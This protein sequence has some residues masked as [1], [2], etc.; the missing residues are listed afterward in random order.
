MI[1]TVPANDSEALSILHERSECCMK[2][3][4]ESFLLLMV[5]FLTW[6][7]NQ[8]VYSKSLRERDIE[9]I[10]KWGLMLL[11]RITCKS[12]VSTM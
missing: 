3:L 9:T 12:K 7:L 6:Q 4:I 11:S 10:A 2:L 1:L 8:C 5:M